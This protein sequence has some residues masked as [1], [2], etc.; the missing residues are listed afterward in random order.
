MF[1]DFP[2]G[3]KSCSF[4]FFFFFLFSFLSVVSKNNIF[5]D[6]KEMVKFPGGG[7]LSRLPAHFEKADYSDTYALSS[8]LSAASQRTPNFFFTLIS[9]FRLIQIIIKSTE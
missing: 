3:L 2:F 7:S 8:K 6:G 9:F 5:S 4:R 1:R